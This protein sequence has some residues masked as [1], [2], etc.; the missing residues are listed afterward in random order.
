MVSI[1]VPNT[2]Q[3]Y[4]SNTPFL[5]SS[6]PIICMYVY[7]IMYLRVYVCANMYVFIH[8]FVCIYIHICDYIHNTAL[9]Y[10]VDICMHYFRIIFNLYVQYV[11]CILT[12]IPTF[13]AVCPPILTITPSGL[14]F[15]IISSTTYMLVISVILVIILVMVIVMKI[16]IKM[17]NN[18]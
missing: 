6:I 16:V 13:K 11:C 14:S 18:W 3:L 2:L 8:V 15:A 5:Y 17:V 9:M 10:F 12:Y 4:L 7:K 1:D